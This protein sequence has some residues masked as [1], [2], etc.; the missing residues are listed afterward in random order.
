MDFF[1]WGVVE[2]S[3]QEHANHVAHGAMLTVCGRLNFFLQ[4][5]GNA[6]CEGRVSVSHR[7][8]LYYAVIRR[9]NRKKSKMLKILTAR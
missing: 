6:Y 3:L 9:V 2:D 7:R 8:A 4:C 1:G 5:G